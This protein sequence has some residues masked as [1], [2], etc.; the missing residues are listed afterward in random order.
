MGLV[1]G[2]SGFPAWPYIGRRVRIREA[3]GHKSSPGHLGRR[4]AG[5]TRASRAS[6]WRQRSDFLPSDS[7]ITGGGGGVLAQQRLR[8]ACALLSPVSPAACVVPRVPAKRTQTQRG[9]QR[10]S[11]RAGLGS[12]PGQEPRRGGG[13]PTSRWSPA[14]VPSSTQDSERA[15]KKYFL[16]ERTLVFMMSVRGREQYK[17]KKCM[18]GSPRPRQL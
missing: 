5:V 10:L 3:V 4:A 16:N 8:V 18:R 6:G 13:A 2:A 7:Q 1:R 9:C 14:L 17:C 15:I 12:E 11:P